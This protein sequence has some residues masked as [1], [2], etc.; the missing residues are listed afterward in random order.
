[1][2]TTIVI[3][4]GNALAA[5]DGAGWAVYKKL[6]ESR[7]PS[8]VRL[9]FLGL[10]GID[11]LDELEGE[12]QLI[13]VDAVQFGEKPGTVHTLGW[14]ELPV[15]EMRPV[16]GH[17]IGIREAVEVGRKLSPHKIPNHIILVGV[18]GECF[19]QLREELSP[20]VAVAIPLA[21][22]EVQRL[23]GLEAD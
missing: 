3:C 16:S 22:R 9:K 17:G 20:A 6:S 2:K 15:T 5:D 10:G 12:E 23:L 14:D 13:V 11:L 4:I 18:E 8:G 19:D 1:M 7:V 21:V